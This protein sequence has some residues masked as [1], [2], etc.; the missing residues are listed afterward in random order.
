MIS[1]EEEKEELKQYQIWDR[2]RRSLDYAIHDRELKETRKKL[3][4]V[5]SVL[6]LNLH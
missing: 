2:M 1:L 6:L 5:S 3:D 4:D